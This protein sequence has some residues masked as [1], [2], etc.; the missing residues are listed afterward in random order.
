VRA[1]HLLYYIEMCR[2]HAQQLV[3][4]DASRGGSGDG[5]WARVMAVKKKSG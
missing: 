4:D 1:W 3:S 2:I 5:A